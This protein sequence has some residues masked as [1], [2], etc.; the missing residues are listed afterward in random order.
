MSKKIFTLATSRCG[1]CKMLESYLYNTHPEIID[2]YTYFLYDVDNLTPEAEMVRKFASEMK[3]TGV[4]FTVLISNGEITK[5]VR[6]YDPKSI[7]ILAEEVID[8]NKGP[9]QLE[10]QFND[11]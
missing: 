1:Y 10:I 7:S 3:V 2:D 6:G 11:N 5:A 4:P 8:S 9:Q